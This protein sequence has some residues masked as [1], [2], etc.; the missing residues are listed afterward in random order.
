MHKNTRFDYYQTL[1][2]THPERYWNNK[3]QEAMQNEARLLGNAFYQQYELEFGMYDMNRDT[4]ANF[5]LKTKGENLQTYV[6]TM[7]RKTKM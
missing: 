6:A 1:R 2:K 4:K 3:T 5:E 7:G